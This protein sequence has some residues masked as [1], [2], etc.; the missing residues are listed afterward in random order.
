MVDKENL[1][2]IQQMV[3]R[4]PGSALSIIQR[5]E[6]QATFLLRL[7]L[8]LVFL[9]FGLLKLAGVSPVVDLLSNSFPTLARSPYLELLGLMEIV[10]GVCLV[11]DRLS[12]QAAA[13]M[14][15]AD[16]L[17]ALSDGVSAH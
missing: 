2:R 13:L 10:I 5:A 6:R 16:R 15:L 17:A 3:S 9:W 1:F 8:A 14:I 7:S 12:K 4:R 11:I